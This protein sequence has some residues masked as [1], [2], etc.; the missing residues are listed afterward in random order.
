MEREVAKRDADIAAMKRTLADLFAMTNNP[1]TREL[2]R[3]T[4]APIEPSIVGSGI[5]Q[6]R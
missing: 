5:P 3:K 6:K 4:G 1:D 2:M